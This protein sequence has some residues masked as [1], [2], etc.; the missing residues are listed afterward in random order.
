M[1][2][3]FIGQ[4]WNLYKDNYP[5]NSSINGRIFEY[6]VCETLAQSGIFPFYFQAKF[7]HVPNCEFDIVL[8]H[9]RKPVVLSVKTS[10]RE[11]YKQ[12]DLEGMAL[13]QVY[14][15]ARQ[16][17]ITLNAAEAAANRPKIAAGDIIGLDDIIVA[18]NVEYDDLL[19]RLAAEQFEMA[20]PVTP[21]IGRPVSQE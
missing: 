12:A 21:I 6:L 3:Q 10:L 1:P 15:Q 7:H 4:A 8:Y 17:L 13:R 20:A 14:R 16:Y 2:S 5:S 9:P 19:N 18:D 11:R